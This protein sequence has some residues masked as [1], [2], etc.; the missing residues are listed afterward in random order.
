MQGEE[1][2][3][4]SKELKT[5]KVKINHVALQKFETLSPVPVHV[6]LEA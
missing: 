1:R 3:V 4:V 2:R 5:V 6:A